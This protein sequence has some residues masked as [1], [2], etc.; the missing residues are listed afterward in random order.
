MIL[1]RVLVMLVQIAEGNEIKIDSQYQ[2][3]RVIDIIYIEILLIIFNF[4]YH[5]NLS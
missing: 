3:S 2:I 5:I 1:V 4:I